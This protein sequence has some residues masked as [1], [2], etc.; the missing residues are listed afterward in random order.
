MKSER[1]QIGKKQYLR[2]LGVRNQEALLGKIS[3]N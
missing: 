2:N 1:P 3:K